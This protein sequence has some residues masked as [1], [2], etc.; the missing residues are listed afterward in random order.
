M[1]SR[2]A[3]LV[4]KYVGPKNHGNISIGA[5]AIAKQKQHTIENQQRTEKHFCQIEKSCRQLVGPHLVAIYRGTKDRPEQVATGFL[6]RCKDHSILV[7]AKHSLYGEHGDVDPMSNMVFVNGELRHINELQAHKLVPDPHNDLVAVYVEEFPVEQAFSL[8][9][10]SLHQET[11]RL[12]TIA[13]YLARDFKRDNTGLH[14]ARYIYT[15]KVRD[16]G[17]GYIGLLHPKSLN[18]ETETG[19]K[20]MA[21]RPSGLSGCPMINSVKLHKGEV[22]IVGVFTDQRDGVAFGEASPKVQALLSELCGRAPRA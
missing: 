5:T 1:V 13:G 9:R 8:A 4:R 7:T 3:G 11:P 10:L 6:V 16:R 14:P 21:P 2:E 17:Y 22:C 15:N 19:T 20:V 18:R 12:V